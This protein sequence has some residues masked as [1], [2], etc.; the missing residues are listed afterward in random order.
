MSAICT[1]P[2]VKAGQTVDADYIFAAIEQL[3][4]P[5]KD[6]LPF[7]FTDIAVETRRQD[8]AEMA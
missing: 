7:T 3:G 2:L 8:K 4:L 6:Q 5:I 1:S